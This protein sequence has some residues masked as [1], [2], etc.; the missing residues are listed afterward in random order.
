MHISN[1]LFTNIDILTLLHKMLDYHG[2]LRQV[3]VCKCFLRAEK[4]WEK[5]H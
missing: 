4:G 2:F 5:L 3:N 1:K